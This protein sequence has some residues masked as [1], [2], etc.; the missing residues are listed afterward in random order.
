MSYKVQG[1]A[2]RYKEPNKSDPSENTNPSAE[3]AK[4]QSIQCVQYSSNPKESVKV[5]SVPQPTRSA[6][7][8]TEVLV[9]VLA[10]GCDFVQLL[11]TQNKYQLKQK[12]PFALGGEA[13]GR[14]T[15]MG[16]QVEG[17]SIGDMVIGSGK[18]LFSE[19]V[20]MHYFSILKL[21]PKLDPIYAPSPYSYITSL[22]ALKT[23]ARLSKG[24]TLLVLGASGGVGSTAIQIGKILGATVIACASTKDKLDVC[25]KLGADYVINY[26]TENLKL[27][28]RE[29]TDGIGANVVYDPVGDKYCEPAV[30]ALAF[31][32]RLIVIGFAAGQ[33]PRIPINLLLLKEAS[34]IGSALAESQRLAPEQALAERHELMQLHNKGLIKPLVSTV[35]PFHDAIKGFEMFQNRKVVGKLMF[36]TPKYEVE[37]GIGATEVSSRID[38]KMNRIKRFLS[39]EVFSGKFWILTLMKFKDKSRTLDYIEYFNVQESV[40]RSFQAKIVF[41]A[42][43][44]VCTVIDAGGL[45]P[46]W[47]SVSI[48]QFNSIESLHMWMNHD[49]YRPPSD[50]AVEH[51]VHA[52]KGYWVDPSK[53]QQDSSI[54]QEIPTESID[55]AEATRL[56]KEKSKN[57]VFMKRIQGSP[58]RF[59]KYVQDKRFQKGRIWKLNLLK[60]EDNKFYAAY[61][62]RASSV[63]S[64]GKI[65]GNE[66]GSGGLK[67]ASSKV[68]TLIGN[69]N[70]DSIAVM[71]YP[72]RDAFTA[73]AMSQSGSSTN[74]DGPGNKLAKNSEGDER[75]I[76]R[77]AGLAV[78]ALIA[79]HPDK[80]EGIRDANAPKYS[81]I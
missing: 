10:C 39:G 81:K 45:V 18:G 41:R 61:G 28:V 14:I 44:Y 43:D 69:V 35:L 21:T 47:E 74:Q 67:I 57:K 55:M 30:R 25:K 32:G 53:T 68:F 62:R 33:I 49:S 56:A 2:T 15:A 79:I 26:E 24:E 5:M 66:G 75:K 70:Y 63:I 52:M 51:E 77:T 12:P 73:F 3:S 50:F 6:L 20:V 13:C 8:Q 40:L 1:A 29:L 27:R 16:S 54:F 46:D 37:F 72:S 65:T 78:Q 36:V 23:R 9:E 60:L 11:L 22:H 42:F 34:I 76:L 58:A 48:V 19:Y 71:Q 80:S 59:L 31:R 38:R 7:K 4:M 17:F 64:T